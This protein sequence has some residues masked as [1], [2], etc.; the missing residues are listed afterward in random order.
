MLAKCRHSE[1]KK[2]TLHAHDAVEAVV[3]PLQCLADYCRYLRGIY[4][5]RAPLEAELESLTWPLEFGG[6]RPA[7]IRV[8][9]AQDMADLEVEPAPRAT[10]PEVSLDVAS[11]LGTLYVLEG[12]GL[13]A[14]IIYANARR[15]GL[16]DAFGA[17]HLAQQTAAPDNWRHFLQVLEAGGHD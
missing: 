15:S 9:L 17:R 1:I 14:R 16:N 3:G 11:L 10:S 7:L 13:G 8:A 2:R 6:W 12:S 4:S 5:F